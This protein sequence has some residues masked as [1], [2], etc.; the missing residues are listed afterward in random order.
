MRAYTPTSGD[1]EVG[2]FDLVVKVFAVSVPVCLCPHVSVSVTPLTVTLCVHHH[3]ILCVHHHVT[4]CVHHHGIYRD[5][6]CKGRLAHACNKHTRA[7]L[8][9]L[10]QVSNK[11]THTRLYVMM[12]VKKDL[13]KHV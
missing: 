5:D 6:V 11:H 12:C 10:A 13:R 7:R 9:M 1:D 8:Y 4:V 3:V 2:F